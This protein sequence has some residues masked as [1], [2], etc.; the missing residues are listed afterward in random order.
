MYRTILE[1]ELAQLQS[2]LEGGVEDTIVRLKISKHIY[3]LIR[4]LNTLPEDTP[5]PEERDCYSDNDLE[6]L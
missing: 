3:H 1:T 4:Y 6:V 2:Y 5:E